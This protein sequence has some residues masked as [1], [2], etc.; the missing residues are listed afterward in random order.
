MSGTIKQWRAQLSQ[1]EDQG[2]AAVAMP[3]HFTGGYELEPLLTLCAVA[4]TTNLRLLTVVLS[5]DYRHPALL[6]RMAATLDVLSDGRFELGLGAGWLREDYDAIGLPFD[7]PSVRIQRLEE[8][9]HVLKLLFAGGPVTYDGK[10]VHV[11]DLVG[12][13]APVQTPHP[14]IMLGGGARKMLSVAGRNADIVGITA[15]FSGGEV[16][17]RGALVDLTWE[18]LVEKVGWAR[19]A[20][21][22]AHRDPDSLEFH[23]A[24]WWVNI[25]ESQSVAQSVLERLAARLGV[26]EAWLD[27][28][29]AVLIG[30]PSRCIDKLVELRERTGISCIQVHAGPKEVDL[31]PAAAIVAALAGRST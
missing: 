19:D 9:V 13:P 26:D 6:H 24:T 10:N 29:P 25:V 20:A 8:I 7:A 1:L 31:A 11:A 22:E 18:R 2:Y 3:D 12:L 16:D 4:Q 21:S 30:S 27:D 15:A 17:H 28:N 23:M 5:A 14:P